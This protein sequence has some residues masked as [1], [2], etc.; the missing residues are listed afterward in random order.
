LA[1]FFEGSGHEGDWAL[2]VGGYHPSYQRPD[3]YPPAPPRVGISWGYDKEIR[4]TG[5][6]YLAITPE[7]CMGGG[8]LDLL[9]QS[10]RTKAYFSAYANFLMHFQPFHFEADVGVTVY[11]SSVI[12]WGILS[13]DVNVDVSARVELWGPPLAGV[14]HLHL[15]FID[16]SVRFGPGRALP[17]R[18]STTKFL[19]MI[20]QAASDSEAGD[21]EDHLFSVVRGAIMDGEVIPNPK[22]GEKPKPIR[23]RASLLRFE[24][25]TRFPVRTARY[26]DDDEWT[27]Q[28]GSEIWISPMQLNSSINESKFEVKVTNTSNPE[29]PKPAFELKPIIKPVAPAIWRRCKSGFPEYCVVTFHFYHTSSYTCDLMGLS[30]SNAVLSLS[31]IRLPR[32]TQTP[33]ASQAAAT[34]RLTTSWA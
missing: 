3:H 25:Q 5:E 34:P 11:V 29:A 32:Q 4:I 23:V 26:N 15:W 22:R 17:D 7:A 13:K 18:L 19:T 12:G 9:Y 31:Q 20:K 28:G 16:I 10:G 8:R 1:Y 30:F 24:V 27:P 2:T 21:I 33:S 14:A 6:A